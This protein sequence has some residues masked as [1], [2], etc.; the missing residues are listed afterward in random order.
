MAAKTKIALLANFR[1]LGGNL[2]AAA[3]LCQKNRTISNFRRL[4]LVRFL[5]DQLCKHLYSSP[6]SILLKCY[7]DL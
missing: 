7:Y 3:D 6:N 1:S 5:S 2:I 4:Q